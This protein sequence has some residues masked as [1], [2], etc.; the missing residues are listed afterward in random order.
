MRSSQDYEFFSNT[1]RPLGLRW[2]QTK[3]LWHDKV[4][5]DFE[6][7]FVV[8][9]ERQVGQTEAVFVN[10]LEVMDKAQRQIK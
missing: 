9:L 2:Q 1:W 6:S 8:P 5:R 10:L 4:A 7:R 3:P